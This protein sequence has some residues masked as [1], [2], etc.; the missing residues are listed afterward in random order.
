[1]ILPY[2]NALLPPADVR[3]HKMSD[4]VYTG[5]NPKYT[6]HQ[7]SPMHPVVWRKTKKGVPF[8]RH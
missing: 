1:M 7:E 6:P 5:A 3:Q 4:R 2:N 8:R